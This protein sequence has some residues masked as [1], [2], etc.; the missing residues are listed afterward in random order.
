MSCY[1]REEK[2]S[3]SKYSHS[4]QRDCNL[5]SS[6]ETQDLEVVGRK[7]EKL[8]RRQSNIEKVEEINSNATE[9]STYRVCFVSFLVKYEH[10]FTWNQAYVCW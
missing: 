1:Y 4:S 9:E 3:S 2:K 5:N 10:V 7:A 8:T 6:S